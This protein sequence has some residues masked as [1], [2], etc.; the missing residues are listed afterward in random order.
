M[1]EDCVAFGTRAPQPG[2]TF[3]PRMLE[4]QVPLSK[5]EEEEEEEGGGKER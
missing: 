3:L 4:P 2:Q 5:K 1:G